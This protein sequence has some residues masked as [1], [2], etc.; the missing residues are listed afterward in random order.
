MFDYFSTFSIC[1]PLPVFL[2][3]Y[4]HSFFVS[5]LYAINFEHFLLQADCNPV[6]KDSKYGVGRNWNVEGN[7]GG[8][9]ARFIVHTEMSKIGRVLL[10][11]EIGWGGRVSTNITVKT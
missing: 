7:W 4:R 1:P 8:G 10:K 3:F 2:Y 5:E 9:G 6:F 11:P